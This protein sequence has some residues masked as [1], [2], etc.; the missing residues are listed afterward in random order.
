MYRSVAPT[1]T[2]PNNMG[3]GCDTAPAPVGNGLARAGMVCLVLAGLLLL[4]ALA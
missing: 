2:R 1:E 4:L 3:S